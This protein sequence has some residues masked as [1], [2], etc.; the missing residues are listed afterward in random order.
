MLYPRFKGKC[1]STI[2]YGTFFTNLELDIGL[3][4][5]VWDTWSDA[6]STKLWKIVQNYTAQ[7]CAYG[8]ALKY[9]NTTIR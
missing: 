2:V 3:D 8:I 9:S 4:T 7:A 6:A 5:I 1:I